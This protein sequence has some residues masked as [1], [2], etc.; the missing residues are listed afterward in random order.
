MVHD[1]G[2]K[3]SE[4]FHRKILVLTCSSHRLFVCRFQVEVH[5]HGTKLLIFSERTHKTYGYLE[6]NHFLIF[7]YAFMPAFSGEPLNKK[8]PCVI[9]TWGL[10]QIVLMRKNL[11]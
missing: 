2:S 8:S 11:I 7:V 3:V 1:E 9:A 6:K 5:H 4:Y 10:M